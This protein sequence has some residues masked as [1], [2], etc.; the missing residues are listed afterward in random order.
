MSVWH[1]KDREEV[2]GVRNRKAGGVQLEVRGTLPWDLRAAEHVCRHAGRG[3]V[4]DAGWGLGG[5]GGGGTYVGDTISDAASADD[6]CLTDP[7]RSAGGRKHGETTAGQG[8]QDSQRTVTQG[9]K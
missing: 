5:G 1:V 8:D 7:G 6:L 9:A 2:R 4:T 3:R